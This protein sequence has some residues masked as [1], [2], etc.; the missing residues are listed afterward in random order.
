MLFAHLPQQPVTWLV[1]GRMLPKKPPASMPPAPA[2]Y[3]HRIGNVEE[4]ASTPIFIKTLADI[5]QLERDRSARPT[6]SDS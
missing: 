3:N 1:V 5:A 4:S 2:P 6:F